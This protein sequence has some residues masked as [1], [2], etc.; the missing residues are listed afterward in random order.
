MTTKRSLKSAL[1]YEII[2]LAQ[3]S[4]DQPVL[5]IEEEDGEFMLLDPT[6]DTGKL[7][8]SDYSEYRSH[9]QYKTLREF[10]L[11]PFQFEAE[12]DDK[13][14]IQYYDYD[15]DGELV[16]IP[17]DQYWKELRHDLAIRGGGLVRLI[18]VEGS[19][20]DV[21]TMWDNVG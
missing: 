8:L 2:P 21:D 14:I 15:K 9:T 6:G 4:L 3:Y 17:H 16:G 13:G 18:K 1:D 10:I 20:T 19:Y 12:V 5:V 11:E 7:D